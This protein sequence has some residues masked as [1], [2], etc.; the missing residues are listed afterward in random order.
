MLF[1]A[2]IIFFA[3]GSSEI[4]RRI[5]IE[6]KGL[7][8]EKEISCSKPFNN[9]CVARY[10]VINGEG[11]HI[12]YSAGPNDHSLSRS[13]EIGSTLDKRMGEMDYSVNGNK[14]DDFPL[15]FYLLVCL[16]GIGVLVFALIA[17][18]YSKK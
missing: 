3:L 13:I 16:F 12:K 14:V 8:V 11:E 10:T 17:H 2:G 9:R 7:V 18:G 6:V 15:H 1:V 5:Y 4:T